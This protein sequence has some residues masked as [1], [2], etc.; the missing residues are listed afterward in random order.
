MSTT[1][2]LTWTLVALLGVVTPG[3]DT[4]LILRHTL[5]GSRHDGFMALLGIGFGCLI[6]ATASLVGLT[7]LLA[8]S[9][10]AYNIIRIAGAVYLIWLGASAIWKALFHDS[11][12]DTD[13]DGTVEATHRGGF[14]AMRGGLLTN[15]LNPKVG[16]FYVSLLPQFMPAEGNSASWGTLLVVIH[17][18]VT[19]TWYPTLIWFAARA[20]KL[21]L[22]YRVRRWMD[23][24]TATILIGLG[25]KLA[26]EVR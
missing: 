16:V 26:A 21:L 14:T 15:L 23:R 5:L 10:L 2:L 17:L 12:R 9:H 6:W 3:I 20:R 4:L 11:A 18:G 19:F 13:T 25:I 22:G 8:A 7:A 24:V 1:A